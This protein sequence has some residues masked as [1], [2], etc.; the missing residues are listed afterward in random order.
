M[1]ADDIVKALQ[2][3]MTARRMYEIKELNN[4]YSKDLCCFYL[5]KFYKISLRLED[6]IIN[7]IGIKYIE[8][9]RDVEFPDISEDELDLSVKHLIS[10]ITISILNQALDRNT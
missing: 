2:C 6:D 8:T 9:F 10:G 5:C 3:I 4:Q 7:N 1:V